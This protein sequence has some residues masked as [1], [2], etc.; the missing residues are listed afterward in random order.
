MEAEGLLFLLLP[1]FSSCPK[2][3]SLS[4]LHFNLTTPTP[5]SCLP[6]TPAL[7]KKRAKKEEEGILRQSP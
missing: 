5:Y 7:H 2:Q 3:W 4:V 1:L 6:P